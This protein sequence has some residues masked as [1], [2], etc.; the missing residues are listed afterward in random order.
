MR[1]AIIAA[2]ALGLIGMQTPGLPPIGN[3]LV[4]AAHADALDRYEGG[5]TLQHMSAPQRTQAEERGSLTEKA[6]RYAQGHPNAVRRYEYAAGV[7]NALVRDHQYA[8]GVPNALLHG[9]QYAAGVPR[10]LL[11]RSDA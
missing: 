5:S 7:P 8:A 2:A 1:T 3:M 11:P 6:P 10:A 4:P 9:H